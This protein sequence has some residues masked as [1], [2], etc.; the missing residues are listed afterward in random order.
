MALSAPSGTGWFVGLLCLIVAA[1]AVF[2][3]SILQ[4]K[5]FPLCLGLVAVSAQLPSGLALLP[6]MVALHAIDFVCFRMLFM[7]KRHFSIRNIE[8]NNV[9]LSK[10]T[11]YH[12]DG[13]QETCK[14][15][16]TDQP[17]SHYCFTPF[18]FNLYI[19]VKPLDGESLANIHY[20]SRK[21]E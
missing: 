16:D 17:L 5:S 6:G 10:S 8:G 19:A 20:L 21:K 11:S 1:F 7:G 2:M 13:E 12:Q 18:P 4:R 3:H 9:F 15:P 14:N